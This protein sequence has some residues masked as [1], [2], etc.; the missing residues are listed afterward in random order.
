MEPD[1]YTLLGIA[2]IYAQRVEFVIYGLAAHFP[3][4]ADALI[5]KRLAS[6]SPED[7]LR[8]D[9][10]KLTITL[11]QLGKGFAPALGLDPIQIDRYIAD[12]NI[13]AHSFY[14]LFHM[15][16][17]GA[18]HMEDPKGWLRLFIANS[19]TL[20]RDLRTLLHEIQVQAHA[21]GKMNTA[22]NP[23]DLLKIDADFKSISEALL[24]S[25]TS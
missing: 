2:V 25:T 18:L 17:S 15:R 3:N 20:E 13:V 21:A 11:G 5:K 14:R 22:P 6:T 23:M 9:V 19:V 7:F 24:L 4:S 16:I 8:G 10:S 12:R 1:E